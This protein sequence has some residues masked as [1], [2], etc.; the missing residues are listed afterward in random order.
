M[1]EVYLA[2]DSRL[3][4]KVAL[5]LLPAELTRDPER[6]SRFI[7]EARA[8]AGVEH[9]HI[10]AIY[11]IGEAGSRT[12]IAMEYV[13]GQSLREVIHL[14]SLNLAQALELAVQV[15]E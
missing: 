4:R 8:A 9:P 6:R 2:E 3:R 1:G 10:A 5:K 12:F 7:H 14:R 15:S 13:R 11:D